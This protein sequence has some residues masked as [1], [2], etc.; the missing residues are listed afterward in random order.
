[1]LL[2]YF[3]MIAGL[4]LLKKVWEGS[5]FFSVLHPHTLVVKTHETVVIILRLEALEF[6]TF[7]ITLS[8]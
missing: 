4:S 2:P 5:R 7:K 3:R 6:L 8:L 1:M